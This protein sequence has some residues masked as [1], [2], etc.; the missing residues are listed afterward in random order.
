MDKKSQSIDQVIK[1]G[2]LGV[3]VYL[4]DKYNVDATL[5][6]LL[7]PAAAYVFA[8]ASTKIGDPNVASFL[9]KKPEQKKETAKK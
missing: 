4:C 8:L 2:A 1:G 9:T 6:A 3:V 5:T 7:M